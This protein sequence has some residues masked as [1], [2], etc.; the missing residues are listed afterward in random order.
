MAAPTPGTLPVAGHAARLYIEVDPSGSPGV[1]TLVPEVTS[2][3]DVGSTR[4]KTEITA[5]GAGVGSNI[6]SQVMGQDDI[7]VDMTYKFANAVHAALHDHYVNG[8]TFGLMEL[9]PE[10]DAT[11]NADCMIRSGE[12]STW[13]QMAPARNGEYKAQWIFTPTLGAIKWNGTIYT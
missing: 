5:H 12:I 13:K 1:F 6:V 9:G 3:I 4:Q 7:T 8:T 10:G 11:L 2:S